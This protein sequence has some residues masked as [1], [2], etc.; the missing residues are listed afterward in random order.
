[1]S[2]DHSDTP[3]TGWR[4]LRSDGTDRRMDLHTSD[5]VHAPGEHGR[6]ASGDLLPGC[7]KGEN[8]DTVGRAPKH[9]DLPH[10]DIPFE[11]TGWVRSLLVFEPHSDVAREDRS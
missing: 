4:G 2:R 11:A 9:F 6:L 10:A 3:L 7:G 1:M 8:T 5:L